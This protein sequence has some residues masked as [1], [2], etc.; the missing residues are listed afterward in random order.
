MK[1][2]MKLFC[3]ILV[4]ICLVCASIAVVYAMGNMKTVGTTVINTDR[5]VLCT[6]AAVAVG[7]LVMMKRHYKRV[8]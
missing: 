3:G 6:I 8:K 1:K 7:V 5:A 2:R 4:M